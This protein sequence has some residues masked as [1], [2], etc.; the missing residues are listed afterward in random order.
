MQKQD[1]SRKGLLMVRIG[2]VAA[3]S[4]TAFM[5]IASQT[6]FS[7]EQR[8]LRT[9]PVPPEDYL[10]APP[11]SSSPDVQLPPSHLRAGARND[12][13]NVDLAFDFNVSRADRMMARLYNESPIV[14][15]HYKLVF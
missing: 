7:E 10:A 5:I 2:I 8:M 6:I 15:P 3:W 11:S 12:N 9:N 14:I 4:L 1:R 13:T